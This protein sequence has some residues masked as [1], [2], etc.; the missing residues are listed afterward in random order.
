MRCAGAVTTIDVEG[1]V[2]LLLTGQEVRRSSPGSVVLSLDQHRQLLARSGQ[3]G[4]V[5]AV[6]NEGNTV[7]IIVGESKFTNRKRGPGQ[8]SKAVSIQEWSSGTDFRLPA[9]LSRSTGS[10][11]SPRAATITPNFPL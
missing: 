9:T 10:V 2:G 6:R 3:L 8:Q 7:S 4:D 11:A 5:L 1:L